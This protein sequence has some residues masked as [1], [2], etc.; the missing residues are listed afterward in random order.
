MGLLKISTATTYESGWGLYFTCII[1]LFTFES[2]IV[3]SLITISYINTSFHIE[4]TIRNALKG[5]KP[6]NHTTPMVSEIH[7]KQSINEENSSLENSIL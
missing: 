7:T 6:E 5:G 1:S 4:T 2:S 3:L